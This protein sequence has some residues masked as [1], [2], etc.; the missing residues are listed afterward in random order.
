MSGV[1]ERQQWLL[2]HRF[3]S[4]NVVIGWLLLLQSTSKSVF[5]CL[6]VKCGP[7]TSAIVLGHI[8]VGAWHSLLGASG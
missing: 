3:R 4:T 7:Y 2:A 6:L 1:A 5:G 8:V